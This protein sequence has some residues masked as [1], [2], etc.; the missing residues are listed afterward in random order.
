MDDEGVLRSGSIKETQN[1]FPWIEVEV[2]I[3]ESE[4]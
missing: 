4:R 2:G 3:C 1:K